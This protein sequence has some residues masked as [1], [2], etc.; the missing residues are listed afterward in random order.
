M[1]IR[2]ESIRILM[3]DDDDD[4]RFLMEDAMKEVL[5][6]NVI[7]FVKDGQ[8]LLD[9]LRREGDYM[10]LKDLPL[11]GLILLDLNMP[12]MSGRQAL[13]EIKS[14]PSL[15]MIPVVI[16]TTSKADEDVL[17]SYN[18]G[19]N[20]YISKPVNFEKLTEVV[21]VFTDYWLHIVRLPI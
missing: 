15:R 13:E 19:S 14:D 7:D 9:Y 18:L 17:S 21:K 5:L 20:S 10:H 8:E 1:N 2:T 4:D 12:R 6:G 11:P 16:L 3:A